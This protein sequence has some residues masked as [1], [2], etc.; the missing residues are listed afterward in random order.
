MGQIKG[1]KEYV[2]W[3]KGKKLTR[4][5]SMLANCYLCNGLEESRVDCKGKGSCP[6]YQYHPYVDSTS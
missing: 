4:K 6:L 1:Q 5:E 2:K 3:L